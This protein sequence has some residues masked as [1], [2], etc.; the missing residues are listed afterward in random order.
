MSP[1]RYARHLDAAVHKTTPTDHGVL[2]AQKIATAP[3]TN[4][5]YDR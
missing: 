5:R 4:H 1:K 3:T 2:F